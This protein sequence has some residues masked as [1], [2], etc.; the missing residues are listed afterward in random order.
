LGAHH[1]VSVINLV[2][3]NPT[4]EIARGYGEHRAKGKEGGSSEEPSMPAWPAPQ[5]MKMDTTR[6]ERDSPPREGWVVPDG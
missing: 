2:I 6:N 1:L 3:L 4:I 5:T